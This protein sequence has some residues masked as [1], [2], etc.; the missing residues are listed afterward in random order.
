MDSSASISAAQV[1]RV[2]DVTRLLAV[3][4]DLDLLLRRM[5]ESACDILSCE[6]AS[7]FLYDAK[8]NALWTKV[9]LQATQFRVP[10]NAGI[11]GAAFQSNKLLHVPRPYED[12]RFNPEPD[13]R[14]NFITRNL[15]TAPMVDLSGQPVGVIQAINKKGDAFTPADEA[16]IQLL[17]DQAGV[18]IQRYNLQQEALEAVSLRREMDLARGVQQALIPAVPPQ[19][20]GIESAGWNKPASITG[21]DAYDLW[22]TPDGRLGI[23]L[24]DATGHGIGPALVVSQTRTLVR[25]MCNISPDPRALLECA[26]ARL[27]D[28]LDAGT[29]VT[30]FVGFVSPD[31]S[32]QW[33]S[34]GHGPILHRRTAEGS[35][36]ALDPPAPPLGIVPELMADPSPPLHLEPGGMLI[37]SSDGIAEA[38]SSG[39]EQFGVER[40]TD[41]LSKCRDL[42]GAEVIAQVQ[43]AVRQWQ[44]SDEPRDDQTL[45]IIRRQ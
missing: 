3:T 4:S 26:N 6:R 44:G 15:L 16:L 21:G 19:I 7:I 2:L 8:T 11:V 29:F 12:P 20:E 39:G 30:A 17:A 32:V 13:R 9:A 23:F 28:D 14:N 1:K 38:F 43:E 25:A 42:G 41:L 35:F 22:R 10:S 24:G 37:I 18:A 27:A 36:Q 33:C 45:V 34:A 5:A 31:G 40:L